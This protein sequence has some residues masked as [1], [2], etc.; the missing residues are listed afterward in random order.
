VMVVADSCYSGALFRDAMP[1]VVRDVRQRLKFFV[2]N[3]SRTILTS[4]GNEPVLDT[5]ADGHSIFARAFIETLADNDD[6]I[7]GEAIYARLASAVR[8]QSARLDV[9]QT[10]R[11]A[12][13]ADAGHGNGQF[14]FR[15][16]ARTT[17]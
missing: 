2:E 3:P 8:T 4:G 5:G 17:L 9:P 15:P 11:F 7:Y 16:Q 6:L 14:V 10:P 12:G 1:A 13:L